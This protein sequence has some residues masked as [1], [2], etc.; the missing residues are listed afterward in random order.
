MAQVR[1]QDSSNTSSSSNIKNTNIAANKA[2]NSAGTI[3]D[4]T[5]KDVSGLLSV[6]DGSFS[7]S[8]SSTSAE[9]MSSQITLGSDSDWGKS[10]LHGVGIYDPTEIDIYNKTYRFGIRNPYSALANCR[11]YLFF[12]KPDLHLLYVSGTNTTIPGSTLNPALTGLPFWADLYSSRKDTTLLNLQNSRTVSGGYYDPFCHLLQNQCKSNLDI[13]GLTSEMIDTPSNNYGVNYS[14]RGSSEASDDNPEFSLEFKD[15]RYLDVFYFFKAYEEYETLK[16]HGVISPPKYYITN[17]IL[18]DCFSI[19]KFLVADDMETIIYW[20]KM[21]GVMPKSLPRDVFSNP[22]FDNGLS[23]SIDF[24]AAF[25]EDMKP[26]ILSD[27]NNLSRDLYNSQTY[28]INIYN[29]IFGRTDTR[30]AKA[31]AIVID[32][33]S[34]AA[35]RSP[36]G[37]LYKLKWRGSDRK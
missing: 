10:I 19:Y 16:H 13:P 26:E 14:Y 11:E 2:L 37:Y 24:K 12:T 23:Y 9:K 31:A 33:T 30:P 34:A 29:Q 36:T 7:G 1:S 8:I 35:Q 17:K 32:R 15:N 3:K 20:G 18:H 4:Y 25:Y 28:Q 21:F 22:E 27:F 5:S 6:D